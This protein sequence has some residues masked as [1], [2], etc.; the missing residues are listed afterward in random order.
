MGE[1][2]SKYKLY[3]DAFYNEVTQTYVTSNIDLRLKRLDRCVKAMVLYKQLSAFK[4]NIENGIPDMDAFGINYD[5]WVSEA[6]WKNIINLPNSVN[7]EISVD[8]FVN[9]INKYADDYGK[10][11]REQIDDLNKKEIRE[12]TLKQPRNLTDEE[13]NHYNQP[14]NFLENQINA[15]LLLKTLKNLLSDSISSNYVLDIVFKAQIDD[16]RRILYEIHD[17]INEFDENNIDK[18]KYIELFNR[19]AK[20][21]DNFAYNG[22][23]QEEYKKIKDKYPDTLLIEHFKTINGNLIK[24]IYD[25]G[26]LNHG[27][28][29][30]IVD[31]E[32][33]NMFRNELTTTRGRTVIDISNE[34][35]NILKFYHKFRDIFAFENGKYIPDFAKLGRAIYKMRETLTDDDIYNLVWII[36]IIERVN[37]NIDDIFPSEHK[38]TKK[39]TSLDQSAGDYILFSEEAKLIWSKLQQSGI[40][41][42]NYI[43]TEDNKNKAAIVANRMM[44]IINPKPKW[45]AFEKLW[46]ISN[47]A[48]KLSKAKNTN[49]YPE[50]SNKIDNILG[51]KHNTYKTQQQ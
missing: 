49:Y 45:S 8:L 38:E 2:I 47:L 21:Y 44:V 10:Q 33:L 3:L 1:R 43:P 27:V 32:E 17:K 42:E 5:E 46:G 20:K 14:V 50:Y 7:D 24:Q 25:A 39:Y 51:I 22:K 31:D 37:K 23:L 30:E 40:I 16:I 26:Y 9:K 6:K 13:R 11:Y 19:Y 29:Y 41:D 48:N 4:R 35:D 36:R 18:E 15:G 12:K 28:E 34:D